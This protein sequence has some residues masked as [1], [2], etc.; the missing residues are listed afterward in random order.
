MS[1]SDPRPEEGVPVTP[2]REL[3]GWDEEVARRL[4][5]Y[6]AGKAPPALLERLEEEW[7]A[8]LA[9]RQNA[10]ARI[11][12]GLGCCWAMRVIAREFG[13]AAAACGGSASGQRLLVASGGLDFS[14]LSRRT[15]A[16]IAI[17]C[18]HAGIFYLYLTGFTPSVVPERSKP[19]AAGF[20]KAA[21]KPDRPQ[22]LPVPKLARISDSIPQQH[23]PLNFPEPLT[24]I[25][26]PRSPR[27]AVALEA[28]S[29]P[30]H[31]VVGGPGAGFPDTEDYYPPA[32]RRLGESGTAAVRV[33]VDSSGRLTQD[34]TIFRSSGLARIDNGALRLARAGSG[35]YR[36]T[37]ENGQPVS[38]CYAY[39]IS[40]RLRDQ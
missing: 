1:D 33:C 35:H 4:V 25:T 7:L 19:I 15:V 18:L 39:L 10:W 17:V 11:R 37:T 6:A 32:A 14:R 3:A 13:V 5:R 20:I 34:P 28:P 38:A 26:M 16:M 9:A 2:R 36:P 21:R 27:P 31:L 40:F 23:L 30:V 29:K 8:D 12:L 22:P 24:S